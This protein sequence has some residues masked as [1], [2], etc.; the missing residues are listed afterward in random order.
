MQHKFLS[1]LF[2]LV[3]LN[4]LVKPL[5]ILG[6]DAEIQNR[7]GEEV[8]GN[9]YALFNFSALF[10]IL[11]DL[12]IV[13]YN[14]RTIAQYPQRLSR[15]FSRTCSLRAV[16]FLVYALFTLLMA[17][18]SGYSSDEF[19]LLGVLIVNQCLIATIQFFRSN[20]TGLGLF[21]SD[22]VVSVLDRSLLIVCCSV[23]LWCT[24]AAGAFQIRWFVYAQTVAYA[25]SVVVSF[26][27][28][29]KRIGKLGWAFDVP[30]FARLLKRSYPYALLILFM[31]FYNRIDAVMLERMLSDGD[32]Q[33]GIYAQ[34]FRLLDAVSMF[35]LLFA[36]LLLPLFARLIKEKG[37]VSG[38][39]YLSFRLLV[40]LSIPLAIL[41]YWFQEEWI[42]LRYPE[43]H[44]SAARTFGWLILSFIPVSVTY[45]FGTLLTANGNLKPVNYIAFTGVLLNLVLNGLLIQHYQT[46]GAA[47]ATLAT[48]TIMAAVQ[49]GMAYRLLKIDFR[50]VIF[51][52]LALL[53]VLFLAWLWGTRDY[54]WSGFSLVA[55][56]LHFGV[57]LSMGLLLGLF[58]LSDLRALSRSNDQ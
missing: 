37:D 20:L 32:T 3:L 22:A 55:V 34:G 26:L 16:F 44:P 53:S 13:N 43:A 18:I 21:R 40:G 10:S 8:Y 33:A 36:G 30:F 15:Q 57:A 56:G 14:T 54:S 1:G 41:G 31:M 5:Y 24:T 46:V 42:L 48:Q 9:Y 25:V 17:F 28:L 19:Y 50:P 52:R 2:V 12:G 51:L 23:L 4:S 58:R 29:G 47:L 7:V 11:L 38:M 35:A 27:L 45:I 49:L 6:I 39:L